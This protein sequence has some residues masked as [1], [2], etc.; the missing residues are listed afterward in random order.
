MTVSEV[1]GTS[2]SADIPL[3]PQPP[4]RK[5]QQYTSNVGQEDYEGH[6]RKLKEHIVKGDII[7][8]V[9]SQRFSRP[10][11]PH[12]FNIYR[13]LRTVNPSPYLFYVDCKG[14]QL[15]CA[16][17]ELL[18]KPENGSIITHPTA[19]TVKRRKTREEDDKLVSDWP[20]L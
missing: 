8:A 9:P 2:Q 20:I 11:S 17:P 5:N 3:P 10:T 14:F 18:V 1:T 16:S 19:G 13:H 7:Q 4:I 15:V 6:V 12:P